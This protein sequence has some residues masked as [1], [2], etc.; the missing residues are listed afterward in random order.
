MTVPRLRVTLAGNVRW[1]MRVIT[2]LAIAIL[3]SLGLFGGVALAN[4]SDDG[5]CA[6]TVTDPFLG[7]TGTRADLYGCKATG[8][9]GEEQGIYVIHAS[10]AELGFPAE[11]GQCTTLVRWSGNYGGDPFLDYGTVFNVT[12][13]SNGYGEVWGDQFDADDPYGA[14]PY[15]FTI[16]GEGDQVHRPQ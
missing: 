5:D 3:A 15:V 7:T 6:E 8:N 14:T 11:Y 2:T 1:H 16:K 9:S 4:P 12:Q 13:C 10:A